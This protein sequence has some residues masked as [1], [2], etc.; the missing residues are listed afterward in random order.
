M[1]QAR[2][3]QCGL[4]DRLG[5]CRRRGVF[6]SLARAVIKVACAAG[7]GRLSNDGNPEERSIG[8]ISVYRVSSAAAGCGQQGQTESGIFRAIVSEKLQYDELTG[9]LQRIAGPLHQQVNLRQVELIETGRA[10]HRIEVSAQRHGQKIPGNILIP[11]S[12]SGS[13]GILVSS[14]QRG[15]VIRRNHD[16]FR[17][18][19]RDGNAILAIPRSN[20]QDLQRSARK[21]E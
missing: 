16:G 14:L 11:G 17:I 6:H 4:N 15:R 9:I 18:P 2:W 3:E 1:R 20:I 12:E 19:R 5:Q 8:W 10:H 13:G 7:R 21:D